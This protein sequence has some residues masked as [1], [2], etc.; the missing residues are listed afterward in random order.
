LSLQSVNRV[1]NHG[2][3]LLKWRAKSNTIAIS[4]KE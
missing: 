3:I 2:N 4:L 1:L